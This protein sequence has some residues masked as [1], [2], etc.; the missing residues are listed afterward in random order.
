[1]PRAKGVLQLAVEPSRAVFFSFEN[2]VL[3]LLLVLEPF[4]IDLFFI[5]RGVLRR[6]IKKIR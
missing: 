1:M 4:F 2:L 6:V 3:G 5:L